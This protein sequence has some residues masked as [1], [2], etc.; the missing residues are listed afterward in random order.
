MSTPS[1]AAVKPAFYA[2]GR[3][4]G[5]LRDWLSLLHPPYTAWHLSYVAIGASLANP[6]RLD[7]LGWAL[8]AFFLGLGVGAHA[9]DELRGHPLRT[10]I[11]RQA[12]L[13]VAILTVGA[14][15]A[16]GWFVGGL[17]LLPFIV[18]GAVLA[19]GYNLEWFGGVL[20]NAVGFSLAWGAFPLLTG[21]FAQHWTIS[22]GAVIAAAAAIA[23]TLAQ[24]ALSTPTRWLRRHVQ[25]AHL[26][27]TMDDGSQGGFSS[28][29]LMKPLE[30]A[31]KAITWGMVALAVA[32]VVARR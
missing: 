3:G 24:R 31:L 23:I 17:H 13:V 21:Y 14:A 5:G 26:A 29:D 19:F 12:L 18:V 7:R 25:E 9:L 16:I 20:H 8:L 15:G 28:S 30:N 1:R 22:V 6:M 2:G 32:L 4:V 11:S 10:G 27:F